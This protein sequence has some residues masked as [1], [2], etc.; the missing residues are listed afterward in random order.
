MELVTIPVLPHDTPS[1]TALAIMFGARVA[2]VVTVR[3]GEVR[4]VRAG[5]LYRDITRGVPSTIGNST[6]TVVSAPNEPHAN[7]S[8]GGFEW[9][10]A[11]D[12]TYGERAYGEKGGPVH[13]AASRVVATGDYS[14]VTLVVGAATLL[15]ASEEF[16]G[17][18]AR[19]PSECYC[20]GPRQHGYPRTHPAICSYDSTSIECGPR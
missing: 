6:F 17:A 7:V 2:G 4:L 15:T 20:A 11:G 10:T 13:D 14:L 8:A 5:D 1:Q 9:R 19:Q 12:A 16:A 18:L 3:H